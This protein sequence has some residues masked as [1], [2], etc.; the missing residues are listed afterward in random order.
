MNRQGHRVKKL[1]D[2]KNFKL[3]HLLL[4]LVPLVVN[5]FSRDIR[6]KRGR[7]NVDD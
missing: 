6:K 1:M 2:L 5:R 4:F 7:K 3:S